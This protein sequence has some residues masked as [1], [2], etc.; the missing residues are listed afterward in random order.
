MYKPEWVVPSY[1]YSRCILFSY[2]S[3]SS[4]SSF[5]TTSQ[6]SAAL[7]VARCCVWT[8]RVLVVMGLCVCVRK[9]DAWKFVRLCPSCFLICSNVQRN[10]WRMHENAVP[11]MHLCPHK[12]ISGFR[13]ID[14]PPEDKIQGE[15]EILPISPCSK[16]LWLRTATCSSWRTREAPG[17]FHGWNGAPAHPHH[18]AVCFN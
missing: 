15:E 9:K 5:T 17:H 2:K 13:G 4:E 11:S 10:P 7:D 8:D 12:W 14:L 18:M 1:I 16:V 6:F 3:G